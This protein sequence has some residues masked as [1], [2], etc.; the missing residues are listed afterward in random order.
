MIPIKPPRRFY[1]RGKNVLAAS[2]LL[3]LVLVHANEISEA[4]FFVTHRDFAAA[5]GDRKKATDKSQKKRKNRERERKIESQ[6]ERKRESEKQKRG[7]RRKSEK[8]NR[9]R[10][11]VWR[12]K[13]GDRTR[14]KSKK[15]LYV[16][17]KRKY[18]KK[19]RERHGVRKR[20]EKREFAWR[21][22]LVTA[23]YRTLITAGREEA[24][25]YGGVIGGRFGGE[26]VFRPRV[27]GRHSL[28]AHQRCHPPFPL[29]SFRPSG[30]THPSRHPLSIPPHP[31]PLPSSPAANPFYPSA[32]PPRP[33]VA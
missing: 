1:R 29:A 17:V 2:V 13:E 16:R 15:Y 31:L 30:L 11:K 28:V 21:H 12:E 14:W 10:G 24:V 18:I 26:C 5:N 19:K 22:A 4:S 9:K 7:K 27:V 20:E 23:L 33:F 25:V 32:C 3:W 6:G 8:K